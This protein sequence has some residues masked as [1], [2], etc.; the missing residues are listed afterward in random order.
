METNIQ[1]ENVDTPHTDVE[2]SSHVINEVS[3]PIKPTKIVHLKRPIRQRKS[4][5][6]NKFVFYLNED[7]FDIG[8]IVD[9]KGCKE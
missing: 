8:E 9:P 7:T 1:V 3:Q 6:E 4:T 2:I 5:I